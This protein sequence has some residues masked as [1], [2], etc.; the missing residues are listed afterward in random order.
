MPL[1]PGTKLGPYEI[2]AGIGAG[3]MGEVY[4]ARDSRLNRQVAVKVLPGTFST[5]QDRLRRF[6]QEAMAA[7]ALNDPGIVAVYDVGAQDGFPY[8]VSELL[9]GETLRDRLR[10]GA[11]S[12]RRS[13]EYGIQITGALAAAH[14]KG[15]VHRDLKPENI[16]ITREG[17]IKL[18]D[19]GL[20]KLMRNEAA[21]AQGQTSVPTAAVG[22]TPGMVLG[23]V[24]YMAPEQVRGLEADARSDIFAV[25]AILYEMLSGE[26]AFK[27]ATAADT[28]IAILKEDPPDLTETRRDIPPALER[29]VRHCLEKNPE[30][31]FRSAHDVAFALENV[32]HISQSSVTIKAAGESPW[33][34]LWKPILG[35]LALGAIVAGAL[36]AWRATRQT[37]LPTFHRLTFERGMITSARFMRDSRN[38]IYAASWQTKPLRLFST[39][40]DSPQSQPLE[41]ESA[42]LLGISGPSEIALAVGGIVTNHL[43]IRDATLA[44]VPVAGGT[45]REILEQVRAADWGPDGNPAVV[46]YVNG[47]QR[48]EYPIGK[49]LYETVGWISHIRV[50]PKGDRI[51]FLLHPAWP[52]DRGF[53]AIVDLAGN[54][55]KLTPEWEGEEGLAWSSRGEEVWFTA[56]SAGADRALYA[57]N[58][59]GKLRAVL[60]IPGGLTLHDIAPDGRVLLS[61]DDERVGMKGGHEG[62]VERDLTWFGWTISQAI[63]PDGK[64]VAFSE[65]SEPAG[66]EYIVAMRSFDGSAPKRLG[67]GH[68]LGFSADG[69]WVAAHNAERSPHV[70]LLPTG[71]GQPRNV[72]ISNL[73]LVWGASFFPDGKRLLL[74]GTEAGHAL[75]TYRVE[76]TGGKATPITP[77]GV[78]SLVLSPDGNELAAQDLSG[79]ITVYPLQGEHLRT[80][81][82]TQGMIPLSWSSDGGY[83][84]TTVSDELPARILRVEITSGKQ[85]LVRQFVPSDSGVYVIW[86]IRVTPDGTTYAYS[87]RQTLSTLYIAQGLH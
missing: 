71:P 57:V 1:S 43:A 30:E 81:P 73:E 54:E 45:P 34:K 32:S 80:V 59:G 33:L 2:V 38:V 86:S 39:S 67:H 76:V 5:D 87:Y 35:V 7:A 63:S 11:V 84:L 3:G 58:P 79:N 9:E 26:R 46:H 12:R 22:T 52:D 24:G 40:I 60:R 62:S 18:L 53:V 31:R 64:W 55:K 69:K 74:N 48:I 70:T 36:L 25:G 20:A 28:M 10:N 65:E 23:T 47:R 75:R 16:F 15:I 37:S 66:N 4:C 19:F 29:I 44:T 82:N 51:A 68:G 50:S 17:R 27:A 85:Q 8:V 78:D 6:E 83:L 13:V 21:A 41:Y 72:E 49:V 56:T 14:D 77:E 61:F 42:S